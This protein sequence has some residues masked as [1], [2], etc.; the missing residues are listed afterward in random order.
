[1]NW[2]HKIAIL[3]S[4]FAAFII[5]MVVICVRQ[6]DIHLVSPEYYKEEIAYQ[7]QIDRLN[8]AKQ[9]KQ[10]LQLTYQAQ[11]GVVQVQFPV[12][13]P[14]LS[15]SIVFFRP[16]DAHQDVRVTV[17]P[18]AA[19]QQTIPVSKLSKGLWKVKINWSQGGKD[20]L[21]EQT[22]VI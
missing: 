7:T 20:Y 21:Q 8:N 13:A 10:P 14:D 9:L 3:Y 16:S 2:G 19:G 17:Q 6:T 4:G 1:M 22:L 18:N 5:G 11:S 12:T 15:G